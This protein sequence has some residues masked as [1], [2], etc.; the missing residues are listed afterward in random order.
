MSKFCIGIPQLVNTCE[1]KYNYL[2]IPRMKPVYV[3]IDTNNQKRSI[4]PKILTTPFYNHEKN[5]VYEV[6]L[7]FAQEQCAEKCYKEVNGIYKKRNSD[8]DLQIGFFNYSQFLD[9]SNLVAISS[10]VVVNDIYKH[11]VLNISYN[12][13][14]I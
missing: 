5:K 8:V 9:F 10:L 13:K 14:L 12:E 2:L 3:L 6:V 11:R 4:I 1:K 7:G